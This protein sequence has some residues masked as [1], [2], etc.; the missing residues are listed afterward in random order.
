MGH[1]GISPKENIL[2]IEIVFRPDC[3]FTP[4]EYDVSFI[5]FYESLEETKSVNSEY[6]FNSTES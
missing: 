1:G 3:L 5:Q 6:N 4:I 2:D